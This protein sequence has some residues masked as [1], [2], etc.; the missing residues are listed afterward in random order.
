MVICSIIKLAVVMGSESSLLSTHMVVNN[1][2]VLQFGDVFRI[3]IE[4]HRLCSCT[5]QLY[6]LGV[7]DGQDHCW[8]N[9]SFMLLLLSS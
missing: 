6:V 3:S 4:Q 9:I 8:V 2:D 1:A 7:S 5:I